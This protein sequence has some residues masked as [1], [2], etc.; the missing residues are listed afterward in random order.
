MQ[1]THI[2]IYVC[3][4]HVRMVHETYL[5]THIYICIHIHNTLAHIR[6]ANIFTPIQRYLHVK[7]P[8]IFKDFTNLYPINSVCSHSGQTQF[9]SITSNLSTLWKKSVYSILICIQKGIQF[10]MFI[11]HLCTFNNKLPVHIHYSFSYLFIFYFKSIVA[12]YINL[13]II[14]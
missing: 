5:Y 14:Y 10:H 13:S 9:S 8:S 2:Q 11:I 4:L 1:Y 6:Q 12:L 3:M 7:L